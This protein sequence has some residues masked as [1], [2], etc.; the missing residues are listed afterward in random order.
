MKESLKNYHYEAHLIDN[1][2]SENVFDLYME[3]LDYNKRFFVREDIDRLSTFKF[4]IDD[5]VNNGNFELWKWK[6]KVKWDI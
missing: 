6:N 5:A 1:E 2:F 4:K 3:K